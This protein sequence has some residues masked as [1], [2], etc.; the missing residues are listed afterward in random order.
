MANTTI[1]DAYLGVQAMTAPQLFSANSFT[2][3]N[4]GAHITGGDYVLERSI[5]H[6]NAIGLILNGPGKWV[7]LESCSFSSNSGVGLQS[8]Q[9]KTHVFCCD[10]S[11]NSL[12]IKAIKGQLKLA[13]NAGNSFKYN[14]V[15]VS[16]QGLEK[17]ELHQGHNT[18]NQQV[19]FDI[20]GSFAPSASISYNGSY[21]YL[22][23]DNTSFSKVNSNHITIGK[24]TVYLLYTSSQPPSALLCPAKGVKKSGDNNWSRS[25][26]IPELAAFPNPGN[27]WVELVFS[28]TSTAAELMVINP[29]GEQI[30]FEHLPIGAHRKQLNIPGSTGLYI[31][32]LIDGKRMAQL[33]WLKLD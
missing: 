24:D 16:F 9:A 17:L 31:I 19:L 25:D 2:G 20:T 13:K 11:H 18:F 1:S 32:R 23:A 14:T 10:F 26:T 5:F 12:G 27:E 30:L 28:P 3:N 29:Q 21:H 4:T 15:G 22:Y 8:Q 33:R 6:N 7:Q